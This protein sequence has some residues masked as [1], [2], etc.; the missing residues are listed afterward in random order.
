[1]REFAG[2]DNRPMS[3]A[4]QTSLASA[5]LAASMT[6]NVSTAS[7]MTQSGLHKNEQDTTYRLVLHCDGKLP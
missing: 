6:P 4:S 1:M 3:S 2:V 7:D 5:Y